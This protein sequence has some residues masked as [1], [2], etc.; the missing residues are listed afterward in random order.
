VDLEFFAERAAIREFDAGMTP[1]EARIAA[2]LDVIEWQNSV[3]AR[4]ALWEAEHVG[5]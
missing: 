2:Q 1:T 5:G 4:K 3:E